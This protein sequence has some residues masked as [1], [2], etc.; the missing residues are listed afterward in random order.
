M[1]CFEYSE[2]RIDEPLSAVGRMTGLSYVEG[3]PWC[4]R[5]ANQ[6]LR[7][8]RNG[9]SSRLLRAAMFFVAMRR[10]MPC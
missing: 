7:F 2:E 4:W 5:G 8:A 1:R 10:R 6:K 9:V 3:G